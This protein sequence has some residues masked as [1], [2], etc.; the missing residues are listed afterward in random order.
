MHSLKLPISIGLILLA[1][2]LAGCSRPQQPQ[3]LPTIEAAGAEF[4]TATSARPTEDFQTR[5]RQ[6]CVD[7]ASFLQDVSIPDGSQ[8]SPGGMVDKRWSVENSGS[9]DWGPDY[10]LVP[11]DP[12]P[13]VQDEAAA[14]YPARSGTT[15]VWRVTF[16]APQAAGEYLG[17]WQ[18]V[19]PEGQAF[20]DQVFVLISVG[21]GEVE[22]TLTAGTDQP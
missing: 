11:Q 15:A 21:E 8:I 22:E 2:L 10:R 14:L 18:A 5:E 7:G 6:D 13:F 12:N 20:G 19:N 17:A 4:T 1:V 3:P 16:Q 9:C